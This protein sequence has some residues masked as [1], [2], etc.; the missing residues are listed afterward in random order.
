MENTQI[1]LNGQ[2]RPILS[3]T[4]VAFLL[5]ELNLDPRRVVVE[6]NRAI[7]APEQ[8][9]QT[10]LANGDVLEIVQMMGGG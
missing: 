2:P 7:V 6:R 8:F 10:Q 4:T 9:A 3:E 1:R 5:K